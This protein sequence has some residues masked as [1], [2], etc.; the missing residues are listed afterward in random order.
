MTTVRQYVQ[1]LRPVA[2]NVG[3]AMGEDVGIQDRSLR[4]TLNLVM[5]MVCVLIKLLVDKGLITDADITVAFTTFNNSPASYPDVPDPTPINTAV[6]TV[7]E[8]VPAA[9]GGAAEDAT[10]GP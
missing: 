8:P 4:I 1:A 10:V 5:G 9:A 7:T 2:R 3:R 6:N